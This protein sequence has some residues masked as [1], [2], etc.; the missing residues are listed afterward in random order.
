MEPILLRYRGRDSEGF[1]HA[2][3]RAAIAAHYARVLDPVLACGDS[4]GRWDRGWPPN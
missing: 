4:A 1:G 3:V 2:L